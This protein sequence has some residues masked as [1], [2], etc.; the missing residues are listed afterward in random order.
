PETVTLPLAFAP[1]DALGGLAIPVAEAGFARVSAPV[2][3]VLC[4]ALAV[5]AC[6]RAVLRGILAGQTR[7]SAAG[8]FLSSPVVP[9]PPEIVEHLDN[10]PVA[11]YRSNR[12]TLAVVYGE[13]YILKTF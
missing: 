12:R 5:P 2:P 10:L 6:C 8:E 9:T 4:D 13:E 1:D 7:S 11:V 3:G